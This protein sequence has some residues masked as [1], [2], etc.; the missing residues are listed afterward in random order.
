MKRTLLV[1]LLLS[2]QFA[3]ADCDVKTASLMTDTHVVGP[4]HNLIETATNGK[5]TVTFDVNVNGAWHKVEETQSDPY[6]KEGALCRDAIRYGREKLLAKLGGQ[7]NSESITVC[8]EGQKVERKIKA[9]NLILETEVGRSKI[10]LYFKYQNMRCRNFLD[11]FFEL[12]KLRQYFGV[13]CQA[14]PNDPMWMV[15]DKW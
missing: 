13:I 7:F 3:W 15:M 10:D 6:L 9:G 11:Q 14:N 1:T 12:G 2:S 4:A 8:R 5:C